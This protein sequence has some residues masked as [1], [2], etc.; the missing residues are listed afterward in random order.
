M[1]LFAYFSSLHA[2]PIS[3]L[4][5]TQSNLVGKVFN[6][7]DGDGYQDVNEEGIIG[8]RLAT[9]TGLIIVTDSNGRYSVPDAIGETQ[10]WGSNLILKLDRAS[11]PQGA[12]LTTENPR[13][14]R[15]ANTGLS[16]VNFG[17]QLP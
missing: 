7:K 1:L 13:I 4:I 6:D 16:K 3:H 14:I 10:S 8:I 2:T 9:M 5:S 15:F 11:L 17:V 12:A